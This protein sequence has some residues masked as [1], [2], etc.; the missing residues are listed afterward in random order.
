MSILSQ[1]GVETA[2][3]SD[4]LAEFRCQ[5]E[6]DAD[7]VPIHQITTTPALILHDLCNFLCFDPK[8]TAKIL[9]PSYSGQVEDFLDSRV[10]TLRNRVS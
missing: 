2:N 6:R 3:L 8:L 4:L 1:R 7:G 9:G 5:L 10:T